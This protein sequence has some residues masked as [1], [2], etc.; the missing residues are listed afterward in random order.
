M[1]SLW[2]CRSL[3]VRVALFLSV[4]L[5]FDIFVHP[6]SM[7]QTATARAA[8]LAD[9]PS[10][11]TISDSVVWVNTTVASVGSCNFFGPSLALDSAGNPRLSYFDA[12][13]DALVYAQLTS[14]GWQT[15]TVDASEAVGLYSSLALDQHG[16]PHIS[17]RDG[18]NDALKYASWDGTSWKVEFIGSSGESGWYSSLALDA[19]DQPHIA[20]LGSG[21]K[22]KY[23]HWTGTLWDIA[24]VDPIFTSRGAS[25]ALDS[26]GHPHMSYLDDEIDEL[27]YASLTGSSWVT[28]TVEVKNPQG[29]NFSGAY[30]SLALDRN[31]T[32]H[33]S[34]ARY[35]ETFGGDFP[36]DLRYAVK[37]GGVWQT[38]APIPQGG[39][40][41]YS[42]IALDMHN[43]PHMSF[44]D[45]AQTA[46]RYLWWDGTAW[47]DS[48][49]ARSVPLSGSAAL[50]LDQQDHPHIAYCDDAYST[51]KYTIMVTPQFYLPV[52]QK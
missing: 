35:G 26:T 28:E 3:F 29:P 19:N 11:N 41:Y 13:H 12:T 44:A 22:L 14:S 45:Q 18:A 32:P 2:S 43:D 51:I 5:C 27:R 30:S 50:K 40:G 31:D 36:I 39:V 46:I 20:Y 6:A 38:N 49:V 37:Q 48:F 25:L 23:A 17:Y 9:T 33:I 52:T 10:P 8:I 42:S 24:V 1:K 21:Q 47:H 15:A 34:Y 4:V 7:A 16:Y